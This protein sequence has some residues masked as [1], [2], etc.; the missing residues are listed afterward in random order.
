MRQRGRD[1][2]LR[3]LSY[4]GG[5][6]RP[7]SLVLLA[8]ALGCGLVASIGIS[9]VLDGTKPAPVDTSPIYVALKN[10]NVGDPVTDQTVSLEEWPTDKIPVG[11]ISK[12][13]NIEERRPRSTIYQGEPILDTKLL[14]KGQTNDPIKGVPKGMRL[15]TISVDARKSAAGLLS[16]GD[17]VDLQIY[18]SRNEREGIK[19]PMTKIFMQNLRVYAVDQTIDKSSDGE[20]ARNVAKTI[21]LI[22][23]PAQASK[24]TLAENLGEVSL[25]PRNPDDDAVV[26]DS[27]QGA[28]ELLGLSTANNREMEQKADEPSDGG[29]SGPGLKT[30]I[31]QAMSGA[32]AQAAQASAGGNANPPWQMT[33]IYP[34]EVSRVEF[35]A[36]GEPLD[37]TTQ[38]GPASSLAPFVAPVPAPTPPDV[39]PAAPDSPIPFPIDLQRK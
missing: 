31:E 26:D 16:P 11:A 17:R 29:A 39:A 1:G 22:V 36:S 25:I 34:N 19:A 33:I 35:S 6:M 4:Q 14:G 12:W 38:Q 37:S 13:E 7:K 3:K 8:L 30:L 21:S 9:Q 24:I 23:T 5:V 32:F 15:Y 2:E 10:I 18:A 27:E 20:E 28:A